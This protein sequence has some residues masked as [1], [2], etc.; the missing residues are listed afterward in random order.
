M[1]VLVLASFLVAA[2][3]AHGQTPAATQ[4][5]KPEDAPAKANAPAAGGQQPG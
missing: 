3:A 2:G 4:S 5:S 1:R